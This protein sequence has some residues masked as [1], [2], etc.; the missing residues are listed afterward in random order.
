MPMSAPQMW[1]AHAIWSCVS[2]G[3]VG[4]EGP[5]GVGGGERSSAQQPSD[6]ASTTTLNRRN[7]HRGM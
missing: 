1:A 4:S 6:A 3:A 2:V 7:H 5:T